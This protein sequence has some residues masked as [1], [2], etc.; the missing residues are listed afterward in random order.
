MH[1]R[2]SLKGHRVPLHPRARATAADFRFLAGEELV[3][4]YKAR[5]GTHRGICNCVASREF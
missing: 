1:C 3:S 2:Q 4:F 5:P